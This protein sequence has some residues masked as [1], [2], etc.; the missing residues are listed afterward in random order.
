M[1]GILILTV[2]LFVALA[3]QVSGADYSETIKNTPGLVAYFRFEEPSGMTLHSSV[4][5][6]G[7]RVSKMIPSGTWE[8][9]P[10]MQ[11]STLRTAEGRAG[12]G[13]KSDDQGGVII[14]RNPALESGWRDFSVEL[15]FKP[16]TLGGVLACRQPPYYYRSGFV[17][18]HLEKD[19]TVILTQRSKSGSV[20]GG[21]AL[22]QDAPGWWQALTETVVA[23]PAGAVKAGRWYH[24]VATREKGVLKLFLNG[25]EVKEAAGP[26]DGEIPPYGDWM[27]GCFTAPEYV[28][29]F[30]G[31]I[32]E[33]AY[34]NT[35]LSP[36]EIQR[37]FEA[38][39]AFEIK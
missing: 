9:M 35:A 5:D 8:E 39:S 1:R 36:E 7:G 15:W 17:Q 13:I 10:E 19:G 28:S 38:A 12:R 16:E 26:L 24:A 20:R 14:F 30:V 4:G 2:T 22:P 6:F 18:L 11:G 23:T 21:E 3:S 31:V 29:H 33:F 37:H 34:Y 32:D 25:K 27:V